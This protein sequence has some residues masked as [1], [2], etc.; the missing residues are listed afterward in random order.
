MVQLS[1]VPAVILTL[2]VLGIVVAIGAQVTED[3]ALKVTTNTTAMAAADNATEGIGELASWMPLIGLV[4]AA[5]VIIGLVIGAFG[6][7][8]GGGGMEGI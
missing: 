8:G 7:F 3:V 2:V 5:A 6:T 4:I 1:A